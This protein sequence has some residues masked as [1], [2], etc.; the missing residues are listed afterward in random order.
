MQPQNGV[1][2]S[3]GDKEKVSRDASLFVPHP[4]Q[5]TPRR[6]HSSPCYHK[7][8]L[9]TPVQSIMG[10]TENRATRATSGAGDVCDLLVLRCE[11]LM[12]R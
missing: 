8:P 7:I 5:H 11:Q 3:A 10:A 2:P 1:V 9:T 4:V 12:H 6:D